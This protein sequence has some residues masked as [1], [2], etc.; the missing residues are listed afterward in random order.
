MS[1]FFWV[2]QFVTPYMLTS[3]RC[4]LVPCIHH[5]PGALLWPGG[6]PGSV[7]GL[8]LVA[9]WTPKGIVVYDTF[10]TFSPALFSNT[11]S[12][13]RLLRL[14]LQWWIRSRPSRPHHAFA[15]VFAARLYGTCRILWACSCAVATFC[16]MPLCDIRCRAAGG[17]F[18]QAQPASIA[19]LPDG[20]HICIYLI[21]NLSF[22]SCLLSL[23]LIGAIMFLISLLVLFYSFQ[24]LFLFLMPFGPRHTE[25]YRV[26]LSSIILQAFDDKTLVFCILIGKLFLLI[27]FFFSFLYY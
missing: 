25:C 2:L 24:I 23:R 20:A 19:G 16:L 9:A 4:F 21:L 6:V 3:C 7:L 18:K 5:A 11:I 13:L 14:P 27:L 10:P 8:Q 12:P 1:N 26:N 15:D 22:L 17:L